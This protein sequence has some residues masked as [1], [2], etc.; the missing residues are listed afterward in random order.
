MNNI[1]EAYNKA[2]S[3]LFK[4]E[5]VD[6][7]S[8]LLSLELR[9]KIRYSEVSKNNDEEFDTKLNGILVSIANTDYDLQSIKILKSLSSSLEVITNNTINISNTIKK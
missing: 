4:Y 1:V 7:A 9:R 5:G 2:T 3:D 8:L 6:R